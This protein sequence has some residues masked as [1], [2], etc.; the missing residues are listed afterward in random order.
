[1]GIRCLSTTRKCS[2]L[3][4]ELLPITLTFGKQSFVIPPKGYTVTD[5][6]EG[7]ECMIAVDQYQYPDKAPGTPIILGDT[8]L[9]NFRTMYDYNQVAITLSVNPVNHAGIDING[10]TP[11]GISYVITGA[12]ILLAIIGITL[13][14]LFCG[15]C[16]C[17]ACCFAAAKSVVDRNWDNMIDD[18]EAVSLED[19]VNNH[20][21]LLDNLPEDKEQ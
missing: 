12:A 17:C 6:A 21:L 9:R 14:C 7:V 18:E 15:K 8:F 13:C 19:K 20:N 3:E 5:P 10:I 2:E 4:D 11:T 16:G 1:M